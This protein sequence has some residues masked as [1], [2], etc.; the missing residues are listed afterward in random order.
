M[1]EELTSSLLHMCRPAPATL[2]ALSSS[3]SRVSELGSE[4]D[5][6]K[7][8]LPLSPSTDTSWRGQGWGLAFPLVGLYII[9]GTFS[10]LG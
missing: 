5:H 8:L 7:A 3:M 6:L 9:L 4:G 10:A 1:G 2:S